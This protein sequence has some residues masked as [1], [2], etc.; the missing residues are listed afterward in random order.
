MEIKRLDDFIN[1]GKKKDTLHSKK[2]LCCNG[3]WSENST[4]LF[5]YDN[6]V[7]VQEHYYFDDN[8]SLYIA[9]DNEGSKY[10]FLV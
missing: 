7:L 3:E 1:Q 9:F 2:L 6:I 8:L 10:L 4:D 5:I